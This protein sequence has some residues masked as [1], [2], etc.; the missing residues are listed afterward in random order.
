MT[1][2]A[3][4][5]TETFN[6]RLLIP[7]TPE[8]L[9]V[10]WNRRIITGKGVRLAV[11]D[12][13]GD[14]PPMVLIHGL[15]TP[16]RSWDSVARLLEPTFRVITFDLRGHGRS[17]DSQDHS[18]D[19]YV[20]DV[21]TVLDATDV[22][23]PILVGHSLGALLALESG[24]GRDCRAVVAVDGGLPL[25]RPAEAKDRHAFDS[26]MRRPHVRFL[27]AVSAL[28]GMGVGL[29]PD[30]MWQVI[31][32][33]EDREQALNAVYARLHCPSLQVLAERADPSPWGE[34]M[35]AAA[36]TAADRFHQAHPHV[37]QVWLDSGHAI[38]L[39]QPRQLAE[40]IVTFGTSTGSCSS[41]S[42]PDAGLPGDDPS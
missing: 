4:A 21:L 40:Q 15:G 18:I 38:P 22:R 13:G 29:S 25:V 36:K 23:R 19:T 28:F 1:D 37:G 16:Q 10:R 14:A 27:M 35:R 12:S 34:E 6:R 31:Q 39:E 24:A 41:P 42:A 30:Q 5:V 8:Q 11:R 9:V 17:T 2:R 7:R 3:A 26:E 33:T 20:E 32:E